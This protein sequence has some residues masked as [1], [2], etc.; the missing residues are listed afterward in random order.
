MGFVPR[1]ITKNRDKSGPVTISDL[2]KCHHGRSRTACTSVDEA[3]SMLGTTADFAVFGETVSSLV[4]RGLNKS[5]VD[6]MKEPPYNFLTALKASPADL[7]YLFGS[8]IASKTLALQKSID[9]SSA[10]GHK[11]TQG[12]KQTFSVTA[13]GL[14][15]RSYVEM[16]R[17]GVE[18]ISNAAC[19]NGT[20]QLQFN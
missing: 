11:K 10:V 14:S 13:N 18:Q 3:V 20:A 8:H 16:N 12:K 9:G 4:N 15:Q 7:K 2:A 17:V 5:H 19:A 6:E 1:H